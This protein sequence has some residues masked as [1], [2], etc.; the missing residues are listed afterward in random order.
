MKKETRGEATARAGWA[1]WQLAPEDAWRRNL[2]VVMFGVFVSFTGFTFVMPFLPLYIKQLGI[3]DPGDA[4]LW[5]GFLFGISPLLSGLLAPL[6]STLAER[7]GRKVMLQRSLAAFTVLIA[8]MAFVTN[9]YQLLA[10]RLAIGIFGGVA[11]MSVA[12]AST[13]APRQRVGEAVGL[14]QATQLA[15]GIA[16]PFIGGVIVD[17]FGLKGSFFLA[18]GLCVIAFLIITLA[19]REDREHGGAAA[20]TAMATPAPKPRISFRELLHLPLFIGLAVAMF[21]IQFIDKSFGPLLPLYIGTLGAPEDRIGTITGVVMTLGAVT[22]S[23]AAVW[24]GRLSTRLEPRPLLFGALLAGAILCVPIAF[25]SHWWQLMILRLLLGLFAG[26]ALTLTYAI[27]GRDMP[28]GAK[29]GAFGTLAGLGQVGGATAPFVTGALSKWASLSAIFIVDAVLYALLFAWTW[30]MF[31]RGRALKP[32]LN[33][34]F[35]PGDD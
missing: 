19:Y 18:S 9:I 2:Y 12:L 4:A 7:H 5:S 3:T 28:P 21:T 35:A 33:E 10:L 17:A 24:T 20:T 13:I 8:L 6:W 30:F 1:F 34:A 32:A 23:F 31:N 11:A 22:A 14:I 29:M 16:A 25:V 27:G 15:S 26:G